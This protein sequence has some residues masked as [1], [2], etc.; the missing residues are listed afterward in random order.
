MVHV[1]SSEH[2]VVGLLGLGLTQIGE[3]LHAGSKL[4]V[5][6]TCDIVR[7]LR[8]LRKHVVS[9]AAVSILGGPHYL[10]WLRIVLLGLNLE[11]FLLDSVRGPVFLG[12]DD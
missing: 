10:L 7:Q 11:D 3:R 4:L 8:K 1:E 2:G 5:L 12:F 9:G 6:H